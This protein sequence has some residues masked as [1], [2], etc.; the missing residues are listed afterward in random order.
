MR[1][2]PVNLSLADMPGFEDPNMRNP[3]HLPP[4]TRTPFLAERG[5]Y[6]DLVPC[7]DRFNVPKVADDFELHVQWCLPEACSSPR[8]VAPWLGADL[9]ART[10]RLDD[11]RG[12]DG[13][14]ADAT[15]R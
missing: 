9:N 7:C 13:T 6:P 12:P 1:L 4:P 10:N 15:R 2:V 5:E 11:T 3:L 8:M 14:D